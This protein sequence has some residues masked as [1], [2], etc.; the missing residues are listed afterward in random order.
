MSL[1]AVATSQ[2]VLDTILDSLVPLLLPVARD[3]D[4]ATQSARDLLSDHHP[5]T[6]EE[7][8]LA[9]EI[10]G[11]SLQALAALRDAAQPD[12]AMSRAMRLRASACAL[13]RAEQAAQR[14]LDALQQVLRPAEPIQERAI[15]VAAEN[16]KPRF[17]GA[18]AKAR[19]IGD[20]LSTWVSVAPPPAIPSAANPSAV[21]LPVTPSADPAV[22]ERG[23]AVGG[24]A[25]YATATPAPF[26][27]E[28]AAAALPAGLGALPGHPVGARSPMRAPV[29][30][31]LAQSAPSQPSPARRTLAQP[32]AAPRAPAPLTAAPS[33]AQTAPWSS[34]GAPAP[35]LLPGQQADR[36]GTT[37]ARTPEPCRA[38]A[39]P[40]SAPVTADPNQPGSNPRA[41]LRSIQLQP[42]DA[43][44][45]S[46]DAASF[47]PGK[48]GATLRY[49]TETLSRMDS[50]TSETGDFVSD[51]LAA[52]D[53]GLPAANT[54]GPAAPAA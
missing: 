48:I 2:T 24:S 29:E 20:A 12:I 43:P 7:L 30:A 28:T 50:D 3:R 32:D 36:A 37:A 44:L 33:A 40:G 46:A 39:G 49:L 54:R 17:E 21:K 26:A 41:P 27:A 52:V 8:R 25:M 22:A 38:P 47:P 4:D 34:Q 14:K 13:R 9:A 10:V 45:G 19:A 53:R 5:A 15:A 1:A 16:A 35:D 42:W 18:Y 31:A 51:F 23:R 11:F 6:R